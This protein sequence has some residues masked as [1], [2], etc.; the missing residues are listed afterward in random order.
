MNAPFV[1]GL[2]MPLIEIAV[3]GFAVVWRNLEVQIR[4]LEARFCN[5][6]LAN[7]SCMAPSP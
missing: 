7:I 1:T 4:F 3:V 6:S 5:D 2:A